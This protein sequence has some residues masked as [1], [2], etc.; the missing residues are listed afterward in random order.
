LN[1]WTK[2][3]FHLRVLVLCGLCTVGIKYAALL[4]GT[5]FK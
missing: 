3:A 2:K 5:Y 4:Q 1:V